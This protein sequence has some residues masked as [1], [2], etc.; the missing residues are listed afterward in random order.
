MPVTRAGWIAWLDDF[1]EERLNEFGPYEDA[2]SLEDELVNHS[3]LSPALNTGL[4][5]PQE[6][7]ARVL[8]K[9]RDGKIQMRSLEGFSRQIIGWR[10]YVRGIYRGHSERQESANAWGHRRHLAKSW[11]TAETGIVPIDSAIKKV[12]R[13]GWLHHIERLMVIS[14]A[15]FLCEIEP[16]EAHRWFMEMFVDSADWVMGPNVYGMGQNADG[17]L[18]TTKPYLCGSNYLINMGRYAKGPW[19]EELDGLYWRWIIKNQQALKRNPRMAQAAN[20]ADRLEPERLR[21]VLSAGERA[22]ARLTV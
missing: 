1:I 14:S 19:C 17:G 21:R 8:E 7:V 13:L 3:A 5:T 6:V 15:M 16:Q 10:E 4:L 9:T 12:L 22:L 20:A 18:M 2:L 11:W